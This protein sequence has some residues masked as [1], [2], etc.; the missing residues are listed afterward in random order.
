MYDP[1]IGRWLSQDPLAFEAGDSNLYRYVQND[2]TNATDP[3]GLKLMVAGKELTK[4][5]D[6]A[7][8]AM[9]EDKDFAK[10]ATIVKEILG[11]MVLSPKEN[12]TYD[13]PKLDDLRLEIRLR[14]NLIRVAREIAAKEDKSF[15]MA[16][17]GAPVIQVPGANNW[18]PCKDKVEG[19][20]PIGLKAKTKPSEALDE[21]M[22]AKGVRIDCNT[23]IALIVQIAVLRTIGTAAYDKLF[24]KT[25]F[26]LCSSNATFQRV[27][28][29]TPTPKKSD[30]IPGD[31]RVWDNPK[32]EGRYRYENTLFVGGGEYFAHPW[33]I[34]SS[35]ALEEKL[36]KLTPGGRAV[37]E[38]TPRD[39]G[40]SVRVSVPRN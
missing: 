14:L 25:P 5:T 17:E 22:N 38:D 33:G 24:D 10:D 6:P 4:V 27:I 35:K 30:L 18:E 21:I 19:R 31:I 26:I 34:L 37:G 2:P 8:T 28:D 39:M 15:F 12:R 23:A 40:Y 11:E 7:Y 3:L 32:G 1:K 20:E 36:A 13:F 9:V 29:Q 16:R